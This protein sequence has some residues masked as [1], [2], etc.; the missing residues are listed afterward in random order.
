V[1]VSLRGVRR[2]QGI[3]R[4]RLIAV[5][6]GSFFLTCNFGA[7]RLP[8][9]L[10]DTRSLVDIFGVAAGI[11]YYLGFAPPRWLRRVWQ[12]PELRAYLAR[13]AGLPQLEERNAMLR[14]LEQGAAAAL[15][16]PYA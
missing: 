11:S 9:A 2:T 8:L 12:G 7:G 6:V 3:T 14:A 10:E 15:G 4:R 13:S 16:A 1:V 5:S